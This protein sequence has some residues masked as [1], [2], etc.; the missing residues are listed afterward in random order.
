MD[1]TYLVALV[2]S[3]VIGLVGALVF[4]A[5]R[6][7]SYWRLASFVLLAAVAADF[8]LLLDWSRANAFTGSLLLTDAAFFIAFG[9]V[10]GLIGALPVLGLRAT[11]RRLAIR[12][13]G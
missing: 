4:V 6:G 10:G 8:A 3:V 13:A 7:G 5:M 1:F 12:R 11:C 9:L 2:F